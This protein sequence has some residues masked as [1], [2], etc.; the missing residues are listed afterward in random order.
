LKIPSETGSAGRQRPAFITG[1]AGPG[2]CAQLSFVLFRAD[3]LPGI[4]TSYCNAQMRKR[5]LEG[6]QNTPLLKRN[7]KTLSCNSCRRHKLKCDR[8]TPCSRCVSTGNAESCTYGR[9]EQDILQ[10][11]NTIKKKQT[12]NVAGNLLRQAMSA[13]FHRDPSLLGTPMRKIDQEMRRRLWATIMELELQ[14]CIERGMPSMLT[15]VTWDTTNVLDVLDEELDET[16]EERL[17]QPPWS[18]Q[19]TASFLH[20]SRASLSLRLSLAAAIND[21]NSPVTHDEVL[22]HD[23]QLISHLQKLNSTS[24]EHGTNTRYTL[25]ETVLDLQLRQFLLLLH[26]PFAVEQRQSSRASTSG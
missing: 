17:S 7:R 11:P 2:T 23:E 20:S 5:P 19:S 8:E 25:S 9:L 22:K 10:Y 15:N 26:T 3:L 13:G 4:R 16:G 6:H 1:V 24:K 18:P 21:T 12:W 14:V